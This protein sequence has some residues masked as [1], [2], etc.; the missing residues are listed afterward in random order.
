MGWLDDRIRAIPL[1]KSEGQS[2]AKAAAVAGLAAATGG[3]SLAVAATQAGAAALVAAS[4]QHSKDAARADAIEQR[5]A[6]ATES[7]RLETAASELKAAR[8]MDGGGDVAG[9]ALPLMA[10]A[11]M[12]MMG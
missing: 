8:N 10:V 9:V 7:A 4:S 11:A 3:A 1:T 12:M 2:A 5:S 6:M